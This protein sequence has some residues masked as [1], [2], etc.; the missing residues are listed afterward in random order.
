MVASLQLL[1]PVGS[2]CVGFIF[3]ALDQ[4]G[5]DLEAPFEN[6]PHDISLTAISRTVEINL[7]QM[8]GEKEVPEPLAP[9]DGV[10]W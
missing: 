9:V 7:R 8:I 2:T 4:I 3:L 10:L 1:T 5:R 6:Q